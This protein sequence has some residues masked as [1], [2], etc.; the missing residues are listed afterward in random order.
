VLAPDRDDVPHEDHSV[1]LRGVT[2]ADY[3][4]MLEIRG[5]HSAPRLTYLEGRLEIMSPSKSHEALKSLLGRLVEV[6]C[7]ENGIEFSALGSWTL[8][9]KELDRGVEPDECYVLGAARDA[10]RPDLA[11]EVVWTSGGLDKLEV[12]RKLGVREVWF[13]R[14]GQLTPH[15]LQGERYEEAPASAALP[16]IDLVEL[17]S[18]LDRTTTSAAIRDYQQALRRVRG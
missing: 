3:Q 13:W 2:W 5:D 9:S 1:V 15:V 10:Q 18:F 8:E 4:R 7:I 6:Y 14:R 16:G 11:I 12:Y 17:A